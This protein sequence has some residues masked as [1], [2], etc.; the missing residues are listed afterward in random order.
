M[1]AGAPMATNTWATA[2][3]QAQ[4]LGPNFIN[5]SADIRSC[6]QGLQ[7]Q[8]APEVPAEMQASGLERAVFKHNSDI[9]T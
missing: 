1:Q 9:S 5:H 2:D 8:Q 4:R 7:W 3:M 6:K